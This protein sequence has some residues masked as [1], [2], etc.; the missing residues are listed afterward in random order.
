MSSKTGKGITMSIVSRASIFGVGL[1]FTVGC[2]GEDALPESLEGSWASVEAIDQAHNELL[3][4]D[5]G[6]GS[7]TVYIFRTVNNKPQASAFTFDVDWQERADEVDFELS[8]VESPFDECEAEDD[9]SMDCTVSPDMVM[10]CEA[11]GRWRDYDFVWE[12]L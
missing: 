12:K 5:G 1:L 6:D 4:E 2:A 9:I 10:S 7:A 3:L 11:D 8:C